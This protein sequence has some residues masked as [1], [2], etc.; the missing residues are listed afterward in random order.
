MSFHY[1]NTGINNMNRWLNLSKNID[2]LNKKTAK[3]SN[4]SVILMIIIG[5]WNVLGRYIGALLGYKLSSNLFIEAQWYLF[6]IICLLGFSWTL[7]TQRHVRVD[8]LQS[9]FNKRTKLKIELIGNLFLL[10]PFAIGVFL[11]SIEPATNSFIIGESSPDPNGLPRYWAK[12]LI[13]TG[14][15]LLSLQAFSESIKEL[16]KLKNMNTSSNQNSDKLMEK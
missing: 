11:I 2:N 7:K 12:I 14:F 16:A 6:E 13:P 3:I 8:V 1:L 10:I 9:K 4:I 5:F 15:C